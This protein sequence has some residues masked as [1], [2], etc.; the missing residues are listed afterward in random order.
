MDGCKLFSYLKGKYRGLLMFQF[1]K[2]LQESRRE[3]Q[4]RTV[5]DTM[6]SAVNKRKRGS[7][8]RPD[9]TLIIRV[10]VISRLPSK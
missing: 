3:Y 7:S 1:F 6:V 2:D 5:T 4:T 9:S 8:P 10:T